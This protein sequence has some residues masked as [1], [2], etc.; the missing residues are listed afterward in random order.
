MSGRVSGPAGW[1][2]VWLVAAALLSA[3]GC[4]RLT[5]EQ[6]RGGLPA[7]PPPLEARCGDVLAQGRVGAY[8]WPA[9]GGASRSIGEVWPPFLPSEHIL[10]EPE[11]VVTL[12]FKGVA[13]LPRRVQAELF[14]AMAFEQAE[15]PGPAL[16]GWDVEAA[17]LSRRQD[18]VEWTWEV[19]GLAA[20]RRE[21]GEDQVAYVLRLRVTWE[22][23][24]WALYY[25]R[26]QV[27]TPGT[28][29][30]VGVGVGKGSERGEPPHPVG[31]ARLFFT[32]AWADDEKT[33]DSL[34]DEQV[35]RERAFCVDTSRLSIFEVYE[36]SPCDYILWRAA[37]P[38]RSLQGEPSFRLKDLI[39]RE[40]ASFARVEAQY[41]VALQQTPAAGAIHYEFREE[42]HLRREGDRW[43]ISRFSR[44]GEPTAADRARAPGWATRVTWDGEK[45]TCGPLGD[46]N[47]YQGMAWDPSGQMLAFVTSD[48]DRKELW[49]VNAARREGRSVLSLPV[50]RDAGKCDEQ[51][52]YFLG[53]S[54]DSRLLFLVAGYQA[55]GP[56]RGEQGWWVGSVPSSGGEASTIAF[57][58]AGRAHMVRGVKVTADGKA[59]FLHRWPDLYRVGLE[60]GRADHLV[61][62]LPS[63]DGLY[64]LAF[65]PDGWW[66]AGDDWQLFDLRAGSRSEIPR[67]RGAEWARLAGWT[68]DGLL[69]AVTAREEEVVLG[70]D[71]SW[72][73]GALAVHLYDTEGR[74]RFC[75]RPPGGQAQRIGPFAWAPDGSALVFAVG[76]VEVLPGREHPEVGVGRIPRH[77][78]RELWLW[79]KA[80]DEYRK[81]ADLRG[82]VEEVEW[83]VPS[84]IR[85]WYRPAPS[86]T[87]REG[88]EVSLRGDSRTVVDPW[89][90]GGERVVGEWNAAVVVARVVGRHLNEVV[91][92]RP[93]GETLLLKYETARCEPRLEHG[94]LTLVEWREPQGTS[95]GG[96]FLYLLPLSASR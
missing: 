12:S 82:T 8:M 70:V 93:D 1:L 47:C 40:D 37:G 65:S 24:A 80:R 31:V 71:P 77:L 29:A 6:A 42:Y 27:M 64:G 35:L 92:R 21:F 57:L 16:S 84:L 87:R 74:E 23:H 36:V 88:L 60:D 33:V 3:T 22:P 2:A 34:W 52:L 17:A 62:D 51:T 75:V 44:V 48:R 49:V 54:Q 4:A 90:Y 59:L 32:A 69:V 41:V 78:S 67:P 85:A 25:L 95:P 58:P 10:T 43:R 38:G 26:V 53:W 81:L 73:A 89:M 91:A 30:R 94:Y 5:R 79:D 55:W 20:P 14:R 76:P 56:H 11:Q 61:G 50:S 13:R 18:A 45:L 39:V 86:D 28:M 96:I 83:P 15:G 68:A 46:V 19:P 7:E 9:D 72:P 66:A 63:W